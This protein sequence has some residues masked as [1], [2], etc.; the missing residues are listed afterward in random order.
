MIN[1]DIKR[2]LIAELENYT[3]GILGFGREGRSTYKF[4][5]NIFAVK[6]MVIIDANKALI[7]DNELNKDENIEFCLGENYLKSAEKIDVIFKS[8]G[9]SFVNYCFNP[10]QKILSQTD[11]FLRFFS[12]QTIGVTGTKGKSTTVSLLKHILDGFYNNVLLIGN[13]GVPALEVV[14]EIA[15]DTIIIFELSSHQLEF[16]QHSPHIA[17]LLNL[18]QEHLDHYKDYFSY[19]KAKWNITKFQSAND[20]FICCADEVQVAEDIANEN[21]KSNILKFGF[22]ESNSESFYETTF[23]FSELTK[24]GFKIEYFKLLG[25]H[26]L[27]N[28]MATL[29]AVKSLRLHIEKAIGIAMSFKSLPHRLEYVA[30]IDGVKF[31]NDSI[32][33]IPEATI[34][35]LESV[36]NVQSLVLGGFNRGIDYDILVHYLQNLRPL[37]L[38]LIGEVGN[39]LKDKLSPTYRGNLISIDDFSDIINIAME[40][41]P[42]EAACILSPAASSYDSFKNFEER[43]DK[44][45]NLIH[46]RIKNNNLN[47]H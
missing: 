18:F 1:S 31:Y 25:K 29:L 27:Y 23:L 47:S 21:I 9:I 7:N 39:I 28:L 38:L 19:R 33:T 34:K 42:K 11:L 46:E 37:N 32:A 20:F 30:E 13:I 15:A 2:T 35:A 40:I 36:P 6:K 16:V 45:K 3:I 12:N 8:P 44:F 5:R 4:L 14:D 41:T 26:N 22:E 24:F 10:T 17:I 43:G